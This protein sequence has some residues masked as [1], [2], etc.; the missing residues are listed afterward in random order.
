MI[1]LEEAAS[2]L[3]QITFLEEKFKASTNERD[4][5][6]NS[7]SNF[8]KSSNHSGHNSNSFYK[9]NGEDR[10]YDKNNT[11][12]SKKNIINGVTFTKPL[13]TVIA[14]AT[15]KPKT[16][17]SSPPTRMQTFQRGK[18][19]IYWAAWVIKESALQSILD[20]T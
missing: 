19:K 2:K 9:S 15:N 16:S 14:N 13:L 6:T 17:K 11:H 8:K 20:L 5:H 10:K 1:P 3:D 18:P 12:S 7:N 4:T